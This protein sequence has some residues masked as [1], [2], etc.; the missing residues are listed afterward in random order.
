MKPLEGD[1]WVHSLVAFPGLFGIDCDFVDGTVDEMGYP[2]GGWDCVPRDKVAVKALKIETDQKTE[3]V[4]RN[5][6]KS[7]V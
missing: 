2:V 6:S 3:L 7:R 4:F 5:G 1:C